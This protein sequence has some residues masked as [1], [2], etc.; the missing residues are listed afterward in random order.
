MYA[1]LQSMASFE[2][3]RI[4]S[5]EKMHCTFV[6]EYY[7]ISWEKGGVVALPNLCTLLVRLK[8]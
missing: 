1:G 5:L 8:C 3:M 7:I 2:N 6:M 4:G